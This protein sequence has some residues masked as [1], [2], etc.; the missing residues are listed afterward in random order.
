[1]LAVVPVPEL[2]PDLAPLNLLAQIFGDLQP[3]RFQRMVA[4]GGMNV[5]AGHGQM[6]LRPE[7]R[8]AVPLPFQHDL[9]RGDGDE[10][11][12]AFELLLQPGAQASGGVKAANSELD[13]HK[14]DVSVFSLG[15]GE[16]VTLPPG[17]QRQQAPQK[18]NHHVTFLFGSRVRRTC[19]SRK[20]MLRQT[21]PI[22][23]RRLEAVPPAARGKTARVERSHRLA[24]ANSI[25]KIAKPAGITR[26]AGPGNAI[27]AMPRASTVPPT[28][29]IRMRLMC[30]RVVMCI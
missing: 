30:L 12:Q 20:A 3:C 9:G 10:A 17:E 25:A 28:T 23:N 18:M 15:R 21:E 11:M 13:F 26:K 6:H 22:V 14:R 29:P 8:R 4:G 27:S 5:R 2:L 7:G 24:Q 16:S 19:R 1:M